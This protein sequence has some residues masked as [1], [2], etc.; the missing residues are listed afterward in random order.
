VGLTLTFRGGTKIP[1]RHRRTL[2]APL[3]Q[4][5]LI[6]GG[7][8]LVRHAPTEHF[9]AHPVLLCASVLL[10][11]V[12]VSLSDLVFSRYACACVLLS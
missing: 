6:A 1:G 2:A 10:P 9:V 3:L 11:C 8:A 5:P 7:P 12:C 4:L